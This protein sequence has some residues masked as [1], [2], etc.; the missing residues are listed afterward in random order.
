MLI[1][2]DVVVGGRR[3]LPEELLRDARRSALQLNDQELA[4]LLSHL[5]CPLHGGPPLQAR[6]HSALDSEQARPFTIC[7]D[8]LRSLVQQVLSAEDFHE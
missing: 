6:T 1:N 4:D 8:A 7:C 5:R 3:I 2:F